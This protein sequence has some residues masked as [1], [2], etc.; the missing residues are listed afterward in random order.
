MND[1]IKG[2]VPQDIWQRELEPPTSSVLPFGLREFSI[3]WIF[4]Y[5]VSDDDPFTV[6][7]HFFDLLVE[8]VD[9]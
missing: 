9:S 2:L 7:I 6:T 5:L 8:F 1:M 4:F 3:E